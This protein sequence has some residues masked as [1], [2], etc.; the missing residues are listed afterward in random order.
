MISRVVKLFIFLWLQILFLVNSFVNRVIVLKSKTNLPNYEGFVTYVVSLEDR[1]EGWRKSVRNLKRMGVDDPIRFNA[2]KHKIGVLGAT[3]SQIAIL[4]LFKESR[5]QIALICED[6]FKFIGN[7]ITLKKVIQEFKSN[8]EAK[9]LCLANL[10]KEKELDYSRYLDR[11]VEVQTRSCYL[12]K[13]DF[14]NELIDSDKKSATLLKKSQGRYGSPD[15]I[16]K[17]LQV[18]NI[19]VVPK[20]RICIQRSGFSYIQNKRIIHIN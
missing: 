20:K 13:K 1:I 10:V 8:P 17:E 5:Q 7:I 2:I 14:V 18:K 3:Y 15:K 19:F 16:W 11:A 12:I 4:E 9:V 6:D